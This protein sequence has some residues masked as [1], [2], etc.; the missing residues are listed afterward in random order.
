[1]EG[2]RSM[3]LREGYFIDLNFFFSIKD[4]LSLSLAPS[5]ILPRAFSYFK[6][7]M[8]NHTSFFY[9]YNNRQHL[10]NTKQSVSFLPLNVSRSMARSLTVCR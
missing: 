8:Q 4:D 3:K 10:L 1:M 2:S 6:N 5:C 7:A 9:Y